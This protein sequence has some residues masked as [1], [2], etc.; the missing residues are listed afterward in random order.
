MLN[1]NRLSSLVLRCVPLHSVSSMFTHSMSFSC[2]RII[3][4]HTS[5]SCTIVTKTSESE[6]VEPTEVA[7]PEPS[8]EFLVE[9]EG[10]QGKQLSKIPCTHLI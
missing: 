4:M 1:G 2:H 10:N 6:P 7:D 9:L 5:H 8:V 3:L